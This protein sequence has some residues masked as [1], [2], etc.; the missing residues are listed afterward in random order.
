MREAHLRDGLAMA[1]FFHWLEALVASGE[2]V[3]EAA[4]DVVLCGFRARD[5]GYIEPSFPTIMGEGPNGAIIHYRAQ[6]GKD[7]EIGADS[8]LLLDSG[9][10]YEC[11]TTDVTRTVHLG[12]PSDFQRAAYTAVLQ[13]N[14]AL[15]TLVFPENTPGFVLD[16]HARRPLW[17]AGLDYRHGTG[18][19]VGAALNVHEGPH[20]I[21]PRF[22]NTT[23]M[24]PGMVVS[25]EPGYYEDG[26]FGIRI[27]HLLS[28]HPAETE[29]SFGGTSYLAFAPLTYIPIQTKLIKTELLSPAEVAWLDAYH[30]RVWELI[31]P[32]VPAEEEGTTLKWLREAT[33]PLKV[34]AAATAAAA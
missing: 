8:M 11:G 16:G 27:E 9:G 34:P 21:S 15:T 13:G 24:M 12:K 23:P 3:G 17:A 26:A 22:G 30:A 25:N 32:R 6:E 14:I 10:Q 5:A 29:H 18:H 20:S 4:A 28:C 1:R 7:R 33:A 31:S 19:G 2:T